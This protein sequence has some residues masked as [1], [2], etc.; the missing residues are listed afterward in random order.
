LDGIDLL[1]IV[2]GTTPVHDRTF[3][4]RIYDQ[5]AVRQGK[6][7]YFRSGDRRRLFDLSVDQHEQADFGKRNPAMLERLAAEFDT[8]NRKMLPRIEDGP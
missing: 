2:K 4:W 3:F 7:K 5:D 8:W 1:P 6:W